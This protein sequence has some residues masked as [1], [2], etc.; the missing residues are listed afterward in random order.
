[1]RSLDSARSAARCPGA[2]PCGTASAAA[3]TPDSSAAAGVGLVG[4][5]GCDAMMGSPSSVK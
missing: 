2:G 1:M 3:K 4:L 5:V